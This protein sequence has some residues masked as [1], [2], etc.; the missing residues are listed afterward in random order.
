MAGVGAADAQHYFG[1]RGGMGNGT[2]SRFYP[3]VESGTVWGLL[4]GG[5]S[6][7][8]Y[9]P[10]PF[11]GG[12]EIDLMW[13]QQGYRAYDMRRIEGTDERERVGHYQ[14]TVDVA[15]LPVMWQPHIYMF[16]QRVR[17]FGNAGVTLSY[18]MSSEEQTS[19]Y[20]TGVEVDNTYELKAT[21]DNWMGYGLCGGGGLAWS[22]GR[23]EVFA[24]ARYYL[25]YSDVMKNRNKYEENPLRSPLDGLQFQAGLFWRIGKGGIRS[26]QG[27]RKLIGAA[28]N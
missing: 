18:I 2:G 11:T 16:R 27:A 25:G 9:S 17:L 12:I 20:D 21:R 13:M 19:N 6:W 23:L 10:E 4:S 15:M 8:Y 24:E 28:K 14:R 26:P 22:A 1:I 7:K 5:V 3:K